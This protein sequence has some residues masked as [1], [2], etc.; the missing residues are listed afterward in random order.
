MQHRPSR[1]LLAST[2]ICA[3]TCAGVAVLPL[4]VDSSRAFTGSI[5]SS[6]LLGLVFAARNLQLLRATGEPSLPPAVLT[7]AFGG[8]FM[9]APLLYPDVGFLP[10]A[11]T[12]LAGTVMAT[13]GLYVVVAGLS[14]E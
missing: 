13:F 4:A 1:F 12:Q 2:A 7:T 5:G 11:G 14:E 10:T 8:W 6:G 3:V 9:L